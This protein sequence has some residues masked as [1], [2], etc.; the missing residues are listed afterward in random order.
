MRKKIY[1][2]IIIAVVIVSTALVFFLNFKNTE[3]KKSQIFEAVS[4]NSVLIIDIKDKDKF[5]E[6]IQNENELYKNIINVTNINSNN[7]LLHFID[8]LDNLNQKS[9]KILNTR[10]L[11]SFSL[12]G[13]KIQQMCVANIPVGYNEKK[14]NS[15]LIEYLKKIGNIKT[16]TYSDVEIIEFMPK[17][18]DKK[19]NFC[20]KNNFLILS[21]S[22]KIIEE[23]INSLKDNKF[24]IIS[25]PG[26]LNI[27]STAGINEMANIYFNMKKSSSIFSGIINKINESKFIN[28]K[29]FFGWAELD[30]NISKDRIN[31]NGFINNDTITNFV[32][33]LE[34]QNQTEITSLQV[35][36]NTTSFYTALAFND[37]QNY[38]KN[39]ISYL[40]LLNIKENRENSIIEIKKKTGL[41]IKSS[42]YSM[43]DGE[44]CY[45]VTNVNHKDIFENSF[46][47]F[48]VNSQSSAIQSFDNILNTMSKKMNAPIEKFYDVLKIDQ[49]TS[50]RY[51]ILPFENLPELLFG[52]MFNN[53]TGKYACC[54]NNFVV[55]ANTKESLYKFV[56]EALLN[57]TLSKSV[58]HNLF[59]ENFSKKSNMFV[60]FSFF[61]G[62]E[63]FKNLFNEEVSYNLNQ[64]VE[65]IYKLGN[66][67]YQISKTNERL[68]NNIVIK[69]SENIE[70][71]PQT[72]WE[73]R[74]EADVQIKPMIFKNH[75]NGQKEII[76]QDK[77]NVLYLLSSSGRII[78]KIAFEEPIIG[79]I[80]QVDYYKNGK[81]QYLFSTSSKIHIID[82]LGNYIEKYPIVLR[83]K[84][85]APLSLFDY[86]NNS[87]YRIIIPC[88]DK[89]LYLYDLEG[90]LIKGWEFESSENEVKNEI[91]H[92]R[93]NKEDFI[94]CND[95]Y[96]SYFISR[97]GETKID[98]QTKFKF[99]QKNKIYFDDLAKIPRFITTDDKGII[100]YFY[101]DGKQDSLFVKEFSINHKFLIKDINFDKKNDYIFVDKNKLEV[102]DNSKKL[103]LSY[104]FDSS[105]S[106]E[107]IFYNFSND[108]LYIG[109]VCEDDKKIYLIGKDGNVFDGFPLHGLSQ[110]TID[111]LSDN[112]KY[113]LIVG[114]SDNL[115]YN[116]EINIKQ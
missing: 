7:S 92:Y 98:F 108:K 82:R 110:F 71:K 48:K 54:V 28:L 44:I 24:S 40:N 53:C 90:L 88:E 58:E 20:V 66:L 15:F 113:N 107:P 116:Y 67:G 16:R 57:N 29:H 45:A 84:A 35:L 109:I 104:D 75:D 8:S 69:Y 17:K 74:L 78:W 33:I 64:K 5:F 13:Q 103:I 19:L 34:S 51:I 31:L 65:S 27:H 62:F 102:Y 72:I 1:Y 3:F 60:Y 106:F 115:L 11:L 73:S 38:D 86:E 59:L 14:F 70:I 26:F 95:D 87:N 12:D 83:S 55:F 112:N 68:Y 46:T 49:N 18:I 56:Y 96:K 77:Q 100:R 6:V 50:I 63:V 25:E 41:D 52:P 43:I 76:I 36:P 21:F 114:G 94:I 105:I 23:A 79:K 32:K 22:S 39:L 93:I 91:S 47:I 99:S 9:E 4:K 42:F 37:W 97:T 111:C 101:L 81:L 89:K 61:K 30:L 10:V 2:I 80:Y 85:T